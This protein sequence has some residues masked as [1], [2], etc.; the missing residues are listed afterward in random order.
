MEDVEQREKIIELIPQPALCQ[1]GSLGACDPATGMGVVRPWGQTN[2]MD[3]LLTL[4]IP[5]DS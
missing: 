1:L 2:S 5:Y 4:Q 3:T